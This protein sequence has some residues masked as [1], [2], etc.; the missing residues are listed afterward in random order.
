MKKQTQFDW[1]VKQLKTKGYVSRNQAL[2][3]Y[4]TRL[5]AHICQLNINYRYYISGQDFEVKGAH[6]VKTVKGRKVKDYIYKVA[7]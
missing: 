6:V 2:S 1:V 3:K 7:G 4:I 5:G